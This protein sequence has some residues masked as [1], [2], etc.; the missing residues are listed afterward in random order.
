MTRNEYLAAL[1]NALKAAGVEDRVD[2]VEE[3]TEHFDMKIADGFSEEEIAAQLASPDEIAQQ[4]GEIAPGSVMVQPG[5]GSRMISKAV[6]TIGV[7]SLDIIA[8]P[9]YLML[10]AWF[11]MLAMVSLSFLLVGIFSMLGIQSFT[12]EG[13]ILIP[14]MPL[15]CRLLLSVAILSLAVLTAF[16]TEY[17]RLYVIQIGRKFIRWHR[18]ILGGKGHVYPPLPLNP[19][20]SPKKRRIMR[21]ISLYAL[22]VFAVTFIAGLVSMMITAGSIEP[23]H[24]WGWFV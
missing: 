13:M 22:V 1:D 17:C 12:S 6:T 7:I 24:V 16:G 8:T 20:I 5:K 14:Y 15:I 23:W 4:F 2:I 21:N 3:Y 10:W 11:F 18:N 19:K 9:L